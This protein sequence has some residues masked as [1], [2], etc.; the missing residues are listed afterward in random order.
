MGASA[1]ASGI[2]VT[3]A[4]YSTSA[5][6]DAAEGSKN[7]T[8]WIRG[9]FTAAWKAITQCDDDAPQ[10]QKRRRR[11]EKE[12]DGPVM[13]RRPPARHA[14]RPAARGR[15]AALQPAKARAGKILRRFSRAANATAAP[16]LHDQPAHGLADTLAVLYQQNDEALD[17]AFDG[18]DPARHTCVTFDP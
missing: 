6:R 15:Y 5:V 8:S 14:D 11:G 9:L 4:S 1:S 12:G 10:L 17:A 3:S 18:P 2:E 16:E 13:M 7:R